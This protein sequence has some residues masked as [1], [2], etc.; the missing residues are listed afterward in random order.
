MNKVI[1]EFKVDNN[2]LSLRKLLS[3]FEIT[4]NGKA[5]IV[6]QIKSAKK[7][8][9]IIFPSTFQKDIITYLSKKGYTLKRSYN[10]YY[11][12]IIIP[13]ISNF[14]ELEIDVKQRAE[15]LFNFLVYKIGRSGTMMGRLLTLE[16]VIKESIVSHKRSKYEGFG[17]VSIEEFNR[18]FR[19]VSR[20]V[21]RED[22]KKIADLVRK[23]FYDDEAKKKLMKL[24]DKYMGGKY[25]R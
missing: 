3:K 22:K 10:S 9:V 19:A 24:V 2:V 4:F 6:F 8:V 18:V 11:C 17:E 21:D 7:V 15:E 14:E 20:M 16:E 5:I 12:S 13:Y 25:E 23:A 1:R